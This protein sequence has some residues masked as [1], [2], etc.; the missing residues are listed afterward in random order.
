MAA[1]LGSYFYASFRLITND[2]IM[3]Y[4]IEIM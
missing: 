4:R 1:Q 3:F 2:I